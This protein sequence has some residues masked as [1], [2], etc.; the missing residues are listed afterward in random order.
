MKSLVNPRLGSL[1]VAVALVASFSW[2]NAQQRTGATVAIDGDDIGGVV[3]SANGPERS[4]LRRWRMHTLVFAEL[5][6]LILVTAQT[7]AG[8]QNL[9]IRCT[10]SPRLRL[11]ATSQ[12]ERSMIP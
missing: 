7:S 4:R 6:D 8:C 2:V 5:S 3:A 9:R 10:K 12:Y 11:S 1:V